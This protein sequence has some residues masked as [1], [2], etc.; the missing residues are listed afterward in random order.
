MK[1]ISHFASST[2]QQPE[3]SP[4]HRLSRIGVCVCWTGHTLCVTFTDAL[5]HKAAVLGLGCREHSMRYEA[6]DLHTLVQQSQE[7]YPIPN[8]PGTLYS[9]C[10][11]VFLSTHALY[12]FHFCF[13][14][15]LFARL[16][17]P[18]IFFVPDRRQVLPLVSVKVSTLW[19]QP[20]LFGGNPCFTVA[21]KV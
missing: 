21:C 15:C 11:F 20:H 16:R 1:A 18:Y 7:I 9:Y 13:C 8:I 5:Y 2:W 10:L 3:N 12:C 4:H 6:L 19:F 17:F 14:C